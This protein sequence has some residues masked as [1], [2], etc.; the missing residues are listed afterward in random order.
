MQFSLTIVYVHW[1]T[2]FL[3][4]MLHIFGTQYRL[5]FCFVACLPATVLHELQSLF[6]YSDPT[7]L[8]KVDLSMKD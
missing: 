3:L 4:N 6:L 7:R 1:S 2:V 5:V 8:V